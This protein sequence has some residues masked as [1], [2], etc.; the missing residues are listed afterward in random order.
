MQYVTGDIVD[1]TYEYIYDMR[2]DYNY[3]SHRDICRKINIWIPYKRDNFVRVYT[4]K[5]FS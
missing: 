2:I 5:I 1:H 3:E 4:L